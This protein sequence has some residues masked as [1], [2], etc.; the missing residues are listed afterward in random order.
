LISSRVFLMIFYSSDP[1]LDG[2]EVEKE[3]LDKLKSALKEELNTLVLSGWHNKRASDDPSHL[4]SDFTIICEPFHLIAT[5][6]VKKKI[7]LKRSKRAGN[8]LL[9]LKSLIEEH[10]PFCLDEKW[11][12]V[13]ATYSNE[14][15]QPAN[16]QMLSK[17]TDLKEWW[18]SISRNYLS[19]KGCSDTYENAATFF[20]FQMFSQRDPLDDAGLAEHAYERGNSLSNPRLVLEYSTTQKDILENDNA[21][22][23]AL[24]SLFGTGKTVLLIA[25]AH[26]LDEKIQQNEKIIYFVVEKNEG[27]SLLRKRLSQNNF[28]I[29]IDS[30]LKIVEKSEKKSGK[31]SSVVVEGLLGKLNLYQLKYPI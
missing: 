22:K 23:V 3:V 20:L 6:E 12:L 30:F 1:S 13:Q 25:K 31:K 26:K 29:S 17:N 8:K 18:D 15:E 14:D 24:T 2:Y 16:T 19:P 9:K 4:E 7:T 28:L 21:N 11:A 27:E 10:I 5:I